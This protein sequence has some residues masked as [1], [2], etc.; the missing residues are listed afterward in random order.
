M[1]AGKTEHQIRETKLAFVADFFF[2]IQTGKGRAVGCSRFCKGIG[3]VAV[4]NS[5]FPGEIRTAGFF[6]IGNNLTKLGMEPAAVV[7][8]IV[9]LQDEFPIG[10]HIVGD[11]AARSKR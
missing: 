6:E 3:A 4:W 9:I 2:F 1:V 8:L 11:A 5:I 7:A 10:G